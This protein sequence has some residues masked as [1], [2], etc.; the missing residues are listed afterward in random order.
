MSKHNSPQ[1]KPERTR[2]I[3]A[4]VLGSVRVSPSFQRVTV[5]GGEIAD[6]A[7]RGFD[8]WFRLFLPPAEAPELRLPDRD[9]LS[10][11][12]QLLTTPK[13]VRPTMR[14]YTIRALRPAG[15]HGGAEI[16]IDFVLHEN[17]DGRLEGVAAHWS[18]TC[19]PGE[20]VGILD[21]GIGFDP[22]PTA[23]RFLLVGDET[24]LPAIAG[25]CGSLPADA[26]GV[27]IIEIP[28]ASDAQD[29]ARPD[30]VEVRWIP[31]PTACATA[32]SPIARPSLPPRRSTT[33][34]AGTAT[35]QARRPSRRASVACS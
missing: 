1:V 13:A 2:P 34:R 10:G 12:A 18:T 11:Y 28:D 9:G 20:R 25:V 35:P 8:Q 32:P 17:A 19:R 5:G 27:A 15:E 3:E 33:P 7:V 4:E 24:A 30:G 26:Q 22:A 16:D 23:D 14:N 21:E 6:L 29:F 31:A